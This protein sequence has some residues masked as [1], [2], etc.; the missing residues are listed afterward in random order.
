MNKKDITI[1]LV[2]DEPDILEIVGYNLT[3]EGYTVITAENG[4]EAV[5]AAK[6]KKP[7]LIILDVM[8]PEMDG[9][10]ACE[11][12]R[13]LPDLQNTIITFLTARGEDYSQVAGFDAGA[14]DYITKPIRPKVLVSKV[15]ALLRRLKEEES[16]DNVVKI[17][18]LVI[19]RDE[20]KIVKDKK[21]IVLPRKEFE[22]LSLLASKPGKVFKREDILDKVWGN[23]VIVGGRTIDV[24]IRKLREK[25]GDNS[26]KTI[27]GVGYKF[28]V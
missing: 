10:E 8:M 26:F 25:I 21:E 28:V 6:K 16:S 2:D 13:K 22:L 11:H 20:Y 27:K 19:N 5:K 12:I 4:V 24:H 17:G 15:K 1:L 7:H 18:N 14:D 23:E 3:A 9:I